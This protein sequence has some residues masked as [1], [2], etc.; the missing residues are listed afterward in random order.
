[1]TTAPASDHRVLILDSADNIGVATRE[2]AAGTV[3]NLPHGQVMLAQR[4]DIGH[5]FALRDIKA[6]EKIIKYQAP[7]G[8]AS[9]VIKAGEYVHTHNMASDYL[10]TYTFD[11]GHEY[12][13]EKHS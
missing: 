5:K 8:S 3:L 2:L 7:I 6:S 4:I 10:P 12:H 9:R 13:Q 11:K 1:M